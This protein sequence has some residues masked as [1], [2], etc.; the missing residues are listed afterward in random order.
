MPAIG[1]KERRTRPEPY[2]IRT[3]RQLRAIGTPISAAIIEELR[4]GGAMSAAEIAEKIGKSPQGVHYHLGKLREIGLVQVAGERETGRRPEM[5]FEMEAHDVH[6]TQGK[7]TPG[8]RRE[9]LRMCRLFLRRAGE[10]Y[11]AAV[12]DKADERMPAG[13]RLTRSVTRLSEADVE[14][15]AAKLDAIDRWL[16]E[17]DGV[18]GACRVKVTVVVATGEA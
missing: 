5:L 13:L 15:L 7:R 1:K 17:R 12:H 3:A 8:L 16:D 6:L 18:A 4:M 14:E 10:D 2:E 9:M 11:E